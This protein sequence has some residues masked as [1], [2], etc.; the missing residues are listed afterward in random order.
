MSVSNVFDETTLFSPAIPTLSQFRES[1]QANDFDGRN[2]IFQDTHESR[3][4]AS[5]FFKYLERNLDAP[6][7]SKSPLQVLLE[8]SFHIPASEEDELLFSE[9]THVFFKQK[10]YLSRLFSNES[11][12]EWFENR[13]ALGKVASQFSNCIESRAEVCSFTKVMHPQLIQKA[14]VE[15]SVLLKG[16]ESREVTRTSK[17]SCLYGLSSGIAASFLLENPLP[18]LMGLSECSPRAYAQQK[19][20]NEFRVNTFTFNNQWTPSVASFNNGNFVVTWGS[21]GQDGSNLGVY[22]QLFDGNGTKIGS[23]FRANSYVTLDQ[24]NPSVASFSNDNFVVTWASDGQDS[25]GDGIYGQLFEGNDSTIGNEFQVNTFTTS[26][27]LAPSVA[28]FSNDNFVVTWTSNVQ[29]GSQWGVYGQLFHGNGSNIGSEFQINT[30]TTNYQGL[31]SVASFSNDNFVVTWTSNVQDGSDFGIYGQLFNGNGTN[32]GSEF[33]INTYTTNDQQYSSVA[34]LADGN[35]VVTWQSEGQDG[36]GFGIYSQLF[37]GSGTKIGSEFLANSYTTN[38]QRWPSVASFINGNFVVT[39]QSEGQDGS[40]AGV[41]GQLFNGNGTKIGSE[42][43][44]N[45]Y[46]TNDQDSPSAASLADGNFVVTWRSNGQDGSSSGIYGQIFHD[47]ITYAASS[48]IFSTT[49]SITTSSSTSSLSSKTTSTSTTPST[50][51][52]LSSTSTSSTSR[53]KISVNLS[54]SRMTMPSTTS[55]ITTSTSRATLPATSYPRRRFSWI[56]FLLGGIGAVSCFGLTG[57]YLPKLR[58][59][60]ND[61]GVHSLELGEKMQIEGSTAEGD[62]Q[63]TPDRVKPGDGNNARQAADGSQSESDYLHT[64]DRVKPGDGRLY[65]RP[66]DDST[67]KSDY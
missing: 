18:L 48:T 60:K 14:N 63:F 22:G 50:T 66:P 7:G 23:E 55:P 38:Y 46:T 51:T 53:T 30:Y 25:S 21:W 49:S 62:H 31:P 13:T 1:P 52:N 28:S 37:G 11:W 8:R 36:D 15:T 24:Q 17:S 42:F 27:Q 3:V 65:G 57:Y 10:S 32:I 6:K 20:G 47:N 12:E 16:L 58:N 41:Y 33:Q 9:I 34:S 26:D 19:V 64:P 59:R 44:V 5:V 40:S 43:Q 29:D 67:A 61:G 39:W 45:T 54:S 35:F 4:R 2:V 56:W